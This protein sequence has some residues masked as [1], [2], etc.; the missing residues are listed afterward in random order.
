M[1]PP[2]RAILVARPDWT[3]S[4][5]NATIGIVER[6]DHQIDCKNNIWIASNGF[7]REFRIM[8]NTLFARKPFDHQVFSLDVAEPAKFVKELAII[9]QGAV[10]GQV[11]YRMRWVEPRDPV[12]LVRLHCPCSP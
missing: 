11:G 8:I 9:V 3:G 5:T 1:F 10:F 12:Y 6:A 2:G 7:A 4:E